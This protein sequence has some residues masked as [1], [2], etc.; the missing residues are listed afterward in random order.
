MIVGILTAPFHAQGHHRSHVTFRN[1]NGGLDVGLFN[2][3]YRG[4]VGKMGR[5]VYHQFAFVAEGES[6][7]HR[8]NRED[9]RYVKF[10]FQSFLHDFKM[11]KSEKSTAESEP[12]GCRRVLLEAEGSIIELQFIKGSSEVFVIIRGNGID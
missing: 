6:I 7:A 9:K 5:V 8:W 4:G 12:Q 3:T 10:T 11:K 1:Q 2:R